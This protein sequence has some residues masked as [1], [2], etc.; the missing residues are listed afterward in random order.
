MSATA[1]PS[2]ASKR[3]T[4]RQPKQLYCCRLLFK[5][6]MI[7]GLPGPPRL[8]YRKT[9][10]ETFTSPYVTCFANTVY[11]I[12]CVLSSVLLCFIPSNFCGQGK[13]VGIKTQKG[14][15]LLPKRG[16]DGKMPKK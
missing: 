1:L 5:L 2:N 8:L 6:G 9:P 15:R 12:F 16:T 14:K 10:V 13:K 4:I 11:P 7:T 3:Q